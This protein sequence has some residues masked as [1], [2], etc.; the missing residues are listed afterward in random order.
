MTTV[1]CV[2]NLL[3]RK[4]N[5]TKKPKFFTREYGFLYIFIVYLYINWI[6]VV[7]FLFW[8]D[9][10]YLNTYVNNNWIVRS[11]KKALMS[12]TEKLIKCVTFVWT[13]WVFLLLVGC[14]FY[15]LIHRFRFIEFYFCTR[16]KRYFMF[17]MKLSA[18]TIPDNME[19]EK[20]LHD[21]WRCQCRLHFPSA[22]GYS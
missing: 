11:T 5:N 14:K 17:D 7:V 1:Y 22:S 16:Y 13:F 18:N 2:W 8:M 12:A 6:V 10:K 20:H 9:W 21:S 4:K 15:I 3:V 19:K